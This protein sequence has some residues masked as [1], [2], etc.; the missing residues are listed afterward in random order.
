MSGAWARGTVQ[1][2]GV[3]WAGF[4]CVTNHTKISGLTRELFI[5]SWFRRSAV[6]FRSRGPLVSA[7]GGVVWAHTRVCKER[8]DL[9]PSGRGRAGR[10]RSGTLTGGSRVCLSPIAQQANPGLFTWWFMEPL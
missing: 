1:R 9:T 10:P 2:A 7:P 6:R 5:C 4:C 8:G 3:A